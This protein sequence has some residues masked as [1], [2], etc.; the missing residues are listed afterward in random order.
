MA[1]FRNSAKILSALPLFLGFAWAAFDRHGQAWH[2]KV[3]HT[4][5]VR[6]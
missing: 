6:R 1:W 2:D 3:A 5:V 4:Y